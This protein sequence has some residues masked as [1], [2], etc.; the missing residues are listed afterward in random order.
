[1]IS[2]S[3]AQ[4]LDTLDIRGRAIAAND[5][6]VWIADAIGDVVIRID[7]RTR[8]VQATIALPAG[9]GPSAIAATDGAVWVVNALAGTV[10]RIDPATNEVVVEAL[11]LAEIPSHVAAGPD[12]VWVASELGDAILR[13]DP[14]T[15]RV[16]GGSRPCDQPTDL[17]A[18]AGR[19]HGHL[20]GGAGADAR[21]RSTMAPSSEPSSTASRWASRSTATAP[22]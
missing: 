3:E 9:S 13:I 18:T 11:A 16:V 19:R 10:S 5:D 1:M 7:P 2:T 21:C 17:V 22:G 4:L 6:G 20:P 15:N 8:G 14:A 12:A